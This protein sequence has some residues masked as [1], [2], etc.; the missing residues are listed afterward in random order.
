MQLKGRGLVG[1]WQLHHQ[2]LVGVLGM[3]I[4]IH[5]LYTGNFHAYALQEKQTKRL[6]A[7]SS[8]SDFYL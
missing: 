1:A 5:Y 8:L 6:D 4:G 3:A 2:L 7:N